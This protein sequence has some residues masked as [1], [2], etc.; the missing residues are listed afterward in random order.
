MCI[1]MQSSLIR[2]DAARR[3]GQCRRRESHCRFTGKLRW[4][5]LVVWRELRTLGC[6]FRHPVWELPDHFRVFPQGDLNG[7]ASVR[8]G[9]Q[10]A[11]TWTRYVLRASVSTD[12]RKRPAVRRF[13][14]PPPLENASRRKL[15]WVGS[16]VRRNGRTKPVGPCFFLGAL[17]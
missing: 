16:P 1:G 14:R 10:T 4:V 3:R 8:F 11:C 15:R 9:G 6:D 2:T 13:G 12:A 17:F 5:P 7:R